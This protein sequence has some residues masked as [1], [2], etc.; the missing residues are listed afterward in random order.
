METRVDF[1][2]KPFANLIFLPVNLSGV[3]L[4]AMFDTGAGLSFVSETAARLAG[5]QEACGSA[6]VGNNN[7]DVS[8]I[9][10]SRLARLNLGGQTLCDLPIG[11]LPDDKMAFEDEEGRAFPA[12]MLLGWDVI[13]RFCWR[14]FMKERYVLLDAGGFSAKDDT[15]DWNQFPI[16]RAGFGAQTLPMGFDSGHTDTMLDS[17][18]LARLPHAVSRTDTIQGIGSSKE[19]TMN[20]AQTLQ[21]KIGGAHVTLSNIE[22]FSRQIYG[23]AKGTMTGLLGADI[24]KDRTWRIDFASKHFSLLD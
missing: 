19:E 9:K 1:C 3:A 13:A 14:F 5:I 22:I 7:G 18:W 23:A 20:V 15:L 8:A 12:S 4:T 2:V 11:L 24:L 21:L 17:T 6:R 10:L 16:V